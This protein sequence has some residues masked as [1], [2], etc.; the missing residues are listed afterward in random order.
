M[1]LAVWP[2]YLQ[3]HVY[4]KLCLHTAHVMCMHPELLWMGTP[5]LGQSLE[6]LEIHLSEVGSRSPATKCATSIF[7]WSNLAR[8]KVGQ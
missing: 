7:D 4:Q 5:Q 1:Q 2:G 6:C 3:V 8:Q